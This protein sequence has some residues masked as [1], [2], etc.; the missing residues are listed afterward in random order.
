MILRVEGL[1]KSFGGLMAVYNVSFSIQR[2]ER[3]AIIGPNG[4]GKSTLFNLLTGHL[5]PDRGRVYFQEEEITGLP[6]HRICRKRISR[7]F[8]RVNIFP[9]L[10]VFE[11]IQV[12][13]LAVQRKS[14]MI[15]SP[16]QKMVRQET[17][18]LLEN[19]G[20]Q[21]QREVISGILSHGDQKRLEL[22]IALAGNPLLL[23]LDEPTQGMSPDETAATMALIDRITREREITLL[24]VEHD[25][26]TVFALAEVI[27][28][29][30][31]GTL[32]AEG[33]P[34]EIRANDEVQRIYL[35]E[36]K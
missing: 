16:A 11:N 20:L 3:C 30:H 1:S 23:L 5:H 7:S 4:A 26:G 19:I 10:S 32:I 21:E 9:M 34:D 15:F 14:K 31:L 22:G 6:P 2:G 25:I 27:R 29:L 18:R 33:K 17:E 24:F 28:V 13:L 8:Q 35:G 12:A 36:R